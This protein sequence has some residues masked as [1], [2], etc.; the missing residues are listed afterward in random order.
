MRTG[1]VMT[2][3]CE[4]CCETFEIELFHNGFGDTS[5]AY[6][7]TCGMTTILSAWHKQWPSGVKCTQA[8]IA[9]E[10][11]PHLGTCGCGGKFAKGNSPR[12]PRCKQ[13]LS[14]EKATDYIESQAPGTKKGWRW[15]RNW[16]EIYCAVINHRRVTDNFAR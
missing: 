9:P 7:D 8:E 4:H 14:A 1:R 10:M 15:Q 5:Y 6:C 11:E 12:C 13:T 3:M 2:G 16:H